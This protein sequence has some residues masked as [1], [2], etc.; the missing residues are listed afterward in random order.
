[1]KEFITTIAILLFCLSL[2]AQDTI[3]F[4]PTS[5]DQWD[6]LNITTLDWCPAKVDSLYNFLDSIDSK[7]FIVLKNG[8]IVL[9]KYFGTYTIDSTFSWYSAAKSL[10]A[11]LLGK[12]Q[13]ENY[14]NI[15][16]K[17]S[18]YLGTGWTSLTTSQEDS[19]TIWNQLT[20]SSGLDETNFLCVNPSCLN[21]V[22]TA[23]TR[24][25]YH[26]GPYSLTRNVLEAATGVNHNI[27]SNTLENLIG[28]NGTWLSFLGNSSYNSNARDMAR[29]GLLVSNKGVWDNEP[30]LSDTSYLN[31]MLSPSQSL[32]PS[33]GYLWW[34]N[35]QDSYINTSSTNT[36][37]GSIAPDA[38]MDVYAAA[39]SF[40]QFISISPANNLIMIRQGLSDNS[41]FT[42][43]EMHNEI[44]KRILNLNCT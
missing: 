2:K 19:I 28:M 4:P 13:E 18:D 6:T 5:G 8:K 3:Y 26:N 42:E 23:G 15:S 27:Y 38:P 35:G 12:A 17:T 10:R 44:W 29:F 34:L 20:M 36:I 9:E 41:D 37:M 31:Q 39:G 24:W 7:S 1:M 33:Y 22:S 25:A 43:F 40:G 30:L 11:V 14:L 32:N 21:Y 16:D